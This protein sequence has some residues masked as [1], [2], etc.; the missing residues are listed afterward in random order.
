MHKRKQRGDMNRNKEESGRF[1]NESKER[2]KNE[3]E[4]V[5]EGIKKAEKDRIQR[6]EDVEKRKE[7]RK[8]CD[9]EKRK[10]EL[11][12][13]ERSIRIEEKAWKYI[14]KYRK[15]K[16]KEKRKIEGIEMNRWNALYGIT[17]RNK[18]KSGAGGGEREERSR[19]QDGKEQRRKR[20][21]NKGRTIVVKQL[22]K[23]T[24]KK[25]WRPRNK[26]R[27]MERGQKEQSVIVR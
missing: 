26:R 24:G 25:E 10:H 23:G 12:E 4:R 9:S 13:E 17:G 7:Y 2:V 3:E 5:T 21:N 15:K 11:E 1:N 22:N 18:G 6:E 20:G 16:E 19:E 14:N 8:W 27:K